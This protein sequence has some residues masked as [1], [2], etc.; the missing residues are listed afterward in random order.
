MSKSLSFYSLYLFLPILPLLARFNVK[1]RANPYSSLRS[2][3]R[4]QVGHHDDDIRLSHLRHRPGRTGG[5]RNTLGKSSYQSPNSNSR[6]Y[7][8]G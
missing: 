8:P 4:F 3:A 5:K 1:F 6:H 7:P 2:Q